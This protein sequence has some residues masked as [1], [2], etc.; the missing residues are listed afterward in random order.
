MKN[1]AV[2]LR[3]S[4]NDQILDSQR[5]AIEAWLE[6][7]KI[8]PSAVTIFS[9]E[10]WSGKDNSRPGFKALLEMSMKGSIDTVVV[11]RLDRFSRDAT[12]A[13]RTILELDAYGVG[14]VS[15]SQPVLNLG[16]EMPFRRTLLAAFSE[17]SQLE[18]EAIVGRVRSGLAAAR[19]RGVKLGRPTL[20]T[21]SLVEQVT[22]LRASGL[23]VRAVAVKLNISRGLVERMTKKVRA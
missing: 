13:I 7:K 23:S 8:Q 10:G 6:E 3:C 18:R 20:I 5:V 22:A 12:T 19:K 14:F 16:N 1:I 11:Y 4:T 17:I 2:Y 15:V 21:N 9:D